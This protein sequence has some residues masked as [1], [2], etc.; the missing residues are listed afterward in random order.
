MQI[1]IFM[2]LTTCT[3]YNKILVY[4]TYSVNVHKIQCLLVRFR[5]L[6]AFSF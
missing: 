4:F 5:K 6:L 1:Y 3:N 2:Q